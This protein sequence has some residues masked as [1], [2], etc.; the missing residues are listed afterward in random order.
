VELIRG[1][2]GDFLVQA[3]GQ[4]VW[5]KKKTGRFPNEAD[6]VAALRTLAP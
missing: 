1:G 6:V 3:A 4:V 2:R 5:D